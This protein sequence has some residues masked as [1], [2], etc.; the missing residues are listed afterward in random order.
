MKRKLIPFF[1][2]AAVLLTSCSSSGNKTTDGSTTASDVS[3]TVSGSNQAESVSSAEE[4]E[5]ADGLTKTLQIYDGIDIIKE[6][7]ITPE[8]PLWFIGEKLTTVAEMID[9][10]PEISDFYAGGMGWALEYN[11]FLLFSS[12]MEYDYA[13][14]TTVSPYTGCEL[15]DGYRMG[16]LRLS[17]LK[18]L[19]GNY[20]VEQNLASGYYVLASEFRLQNIDQPPFTYEGRTYTAYEASQQMRKMERAMRKQKDRCIVADAAGDEEA[21]ATASIRLNRQKYIY[22][23]F[24]KAADSYTEY[25]R[26]YVTGFNRS[27]AARSGV[28]AIKKEYK[29]IASTLDKSA[30]PS[31]DDFKKMLYNNSDTICYNFST[32]YF[33]RA[34]KA[35]ESRIPN[36]KKGRAS[37]DVDDSRTQ[38]YVADDNHITVY[39]DYPTDVVCIKSEKDIEK[40]LT[41]N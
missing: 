1:L 41:Q 8:S 9:E 25:E 6:Y 39:N 27:I 18:D 12:D 5:Q 35:L 22:E 11:D 33:N 29:L 40:Y 37:H 38:E 3:Q 32:E 13:R 24:C 17:E 23:D 4:T 34:C 31:I 21:F 28:A 10:E 19:L 26:T 16:Y 2:S 30:V 14:V 7:D 15:F 36:I 20:D